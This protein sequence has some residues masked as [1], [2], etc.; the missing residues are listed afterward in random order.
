MYRV[1]KALY[2]LNQALRAWYDTLSSYLLTKGY[3]RGN[4]DKTLFVNR[5]KGDIILV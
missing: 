3:V 1:R 2:G 4:A 5:D